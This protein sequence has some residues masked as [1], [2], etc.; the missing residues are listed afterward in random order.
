MWLIVLGIFGL[1]CFFGLGAFAFELGFLFSL[2]GGCLVWGIVWIVLD[3]VP[4]S[5]GGLVDSLV[6]VSLLARGGPVGES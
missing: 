6:E 5:S 2:L 4:P 1:A 3:H